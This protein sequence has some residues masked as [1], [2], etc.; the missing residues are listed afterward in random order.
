VE[1]GC[2]ASDS[3]YHAALISGLEQVKSAVTLYRQVVTWIN[4]KVEHSGPKSSYL[5]WR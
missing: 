1:V 4:G 5:S 2:V 3:D